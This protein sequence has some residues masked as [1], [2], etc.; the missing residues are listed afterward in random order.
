MPRVG[1][2]VLSWISAALRSASEGVVLLVA[3]A[4]DGVVITRD[5]NPRVRC[6]RSN[7]KVRSRS[8]LKN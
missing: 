6:C 7:L 8:E 5:Q 1:C 3:A 4:V 2:S